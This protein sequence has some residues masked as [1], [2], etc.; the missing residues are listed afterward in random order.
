MSLTD[1][2]Q[3]QTLIRGGNY[4]KDKIFPQ[5]DLMDLKSKSNIKQ[6]N[7]IIITGLQDLAFVMPSFDMI[8]EMAAGVQ[9]G[10]Q[11]NI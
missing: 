2:I 6:S 3:K 5:A 4:L 9:P 11:R 10:E 8:K 1:M 7:N